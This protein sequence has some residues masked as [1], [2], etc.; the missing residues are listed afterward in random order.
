L[1]R[2]I[3]EEPPTGETER[4]AIRL[5]YVRDPIA[6]DTPLTFLDSSLVREFSKKVK[7]NLRK[8]ENDANFEAS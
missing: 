2:D 8:T 6:E 4:I 1:Y 3:P 7:T 5:F